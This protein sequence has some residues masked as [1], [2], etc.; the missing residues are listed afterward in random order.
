MKGKTDKYTDS[1]AD[2]NRQKDRSRQRQG[3]LRHSSD[4]NSCSDIFA[5]GSFTL[6]RR[7]NV[8]TVAVYTQGGPVT[9]K[10]FHL[11]LDCTLYRILRTT[12]TVDEQLV[13]QCQC[14]RIFEI[15]RS[16][17]RKKKQNNN[18]NKS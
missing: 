14:D 8:V 4:N 2:K 3:H 13:L 1:E 12:V 16:W 5:V 9:V 17:K 7:F 15:F 10:V 18:N 6:G 11:N